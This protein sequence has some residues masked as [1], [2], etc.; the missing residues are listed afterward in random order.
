[1]EKNQYSAVLGPNVSLL[2]SCMLPMWQGV[3]EKYMLWFDTSLNIREITN[4]D[5]TG[6][7]WLLEVDRMDAEKHVVPGVDKE[8]IP[9]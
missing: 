7:V 3:S 2:A 6:G 4:H 9:R 5:M 1:M 8:P